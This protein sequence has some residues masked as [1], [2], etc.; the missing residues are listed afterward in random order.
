MADPTVTLNMRAA[1]D[2]MNDMF[3]DD[4]PTQS[5]GGMGG[6][7]AD[8]GSDA[9]D[10]TM[11]VNTRAAMD[12]VRPRKALLCSAG[13][14]GAAAWLSSGPDS[15][16]CD[17]KHL[18]C[19]QL[20][21]WHAMPHL[22]CFS[23]AATA[24]RSTAGWLAA[25]HA[26]PQLSGG[27][28]VCCSVRPQVNRMFLGGGDTT[29]LRLPGKMGKVGGGHDGRSCPAGAHCCNRSSHDGVRC[30]GETGTPHTHTHAHTHVAHT[31]THATLV[32]RPAMHDRS[33][34]D[35]A[36]AAPAPPQ[37]PQPA[38]ADLNAMRHRQ[39]GGPAEAAGSQQ[40]QLQPQSGGLEVYEDTQFIGHGEAAHGSA[41]GGRG[42]EGGGLGLYEDTGAPGVG[43]GGVGAGYPVDGMAAAAVD[44]GCWLGA[45]AARQLE[46]GRS[47]QAGRP[48][49]EQLPGHPRS[50]AP[51]PCCLCVCRVHHARHGARSSSSQP[52]RLGGGRR[53]QQQQPG[54]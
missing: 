31:Q 37:A 14:A 20:A 38:A 35:R 2:A 15:A 48:G 22:A 9:F 26:M 30:L 10:P 50:L 12:M 47:K 42:E 34:T 23:P 41:G 24:A 3:C 21:A 25:R 53:G 45:D 43:W 40:H 52:C 8:E 32:E 51:C 16:F 54:V 44:L 7:G 46:Q 28:G 13:A 39:G 19:R 4:L 11:T 1:L 33:R 27:R 6:C 29:T 36:C 17:R 5:L 18:L 49:R